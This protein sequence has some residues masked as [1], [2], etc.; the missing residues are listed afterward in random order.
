MSFLPPLRARLQASS[1]LRLAGVS[2]AVVAQPLLDAVARSPEFLVA[3]EL[4]RADVFV[5]V[6][7]LVVVVPTA[8]LLPVALLRAVRGPWLLLESS[9]I[10]GLLALLSMQVASRL[11]ARSAWVAVPVSVLA[12]AFAARVYQ[13]HAAVR[14][15]AAMTAIGVVAVPALFLTSASIRPLVRPVDDPA[16]NRPRPADAAVRQGTAVPVVL[17]VF[18][19][20]PLLSLQS[21]AGG[22]D[23]RH[24]PSFAQLARDGVLF[25]NATTVS[26][27]TQWAVP[28]MLSGRLPR[29]GTEGDQSASLYALL[30]GTYRFTVSDTATSL[31][32]ADLCP[33]ATPSMTTR[34]TML[35]NDLWYVYL[36]ALATPDLARRL[37]SLTD[38]WRNFGRLGEWRREGQAEQARRRPGTINQAVAE[39]FVDRIRPDRGQPGLFMLHTLLP[40]FPH[41]QVPGGRFNGTRTDV[42]AFTSPED[43]SADP[44]AVAQLEQRHQ[45]QL[46]VV[47]AYLGRLLDRLRQAD[48]Y[49]RALVVVTSDHGISFEPGTSRR[50]FST[51]TAAEIMRVP[52]LLKMPDGMPPPPSVLVD[53]Q[54]VSDR[55]ARTIDILPTVADVLDVPV[56]WQVDGV[57]L[58]DSSRPEPPSK[59]IF[60]DNATRSQDYDRAGPDPA[61]ARARKRRLFDAPGNDHF[62]PRPDRFAEL[63]GR[64]VADLRVEPG[65]AVVYVDHL[66]A[67]LAFDDRGGDAAFEV[68]GRF[69]PSSAAPGP[70][71]YVAVAVNGS[72]AAVTRT[73]TSEPDGWQATP[74]PGVWRT[75]APG[76]PGANDIRV[77]T[78]EEEEGEDEEGKDEDARR[79]RLRS[80]E[81]RPR[82]GIE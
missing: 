39:A 58:L 8:L 22:I 42:P 26:D 32:P 4:T 57:S 14:A 76:S 18:D 54:H 82:T 28:A 29:P 78:V 68:A 46:Q 2:A 65:T 53:G 19:E 40:H 72:I 77:F 66:D 51:A 13:R 24:Y 43:W 20:T 75:G 73:W 11:G 60:Y 49:H 7:G 52:L 31:C 1:W 50:R 48:I 80:C 81:V 6:F 63:I 69:A 74:P 61:A 30:A 70:P 79:P 67:F 37:P 55:N 35:A 36:H 62:A 9:V 41:L 44:V 34:L 17:L 5:A 27:Y 3:H 15:A 47:D 25:R 16:V 10:G 64:P 12:G 33:P 45:R 56:P 23:A 59:T 21:G 38:D 71:R